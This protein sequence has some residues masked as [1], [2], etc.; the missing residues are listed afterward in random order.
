MDVVIIDIGAEGVFG[1]RIVSLFKEKGVGGSI[2]S[3]Q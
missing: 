1:G 2:I 3:I